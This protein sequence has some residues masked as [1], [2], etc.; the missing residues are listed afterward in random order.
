MELCLGPLPSRCVLKWAADA[1]ASMKA[2]STG[3]AQ[4]P[5]HVGDEFFEGTRELVREWVALAREHDVF[6]WHDEVDADQ[7]LIR[8][9]WWR[10]LV[11]V[12]SDL[13][14]EGLIPPMDRDA[15]RFALELRTAMLHTLVATGRMTEETAA[16][17]AAAWPAL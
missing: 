2:A 11:M 14:E 15:A 3:A 6:E 7:L 17:T 9:Q 10:N 16:R 1:I 4:L 5:F 13:L 12:R 8:L